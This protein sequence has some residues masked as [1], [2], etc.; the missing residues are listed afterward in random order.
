M[1]IIYNNSRTLV[2]VVCNPSVDFGCTLMRYKDKCDIIELLDN[3]KYALCRLLAR[4]ACRVDKFNIGKVALLGL[5]AVQPLNLVYAWSTLTERYGLRL[6][7]CHCKQTDN[8][9]HYIYDKS[10]HIS[11]TIIINYKDIIFWVKVQKKNI[12]MEDVLF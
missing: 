1:R 4:D 12:S 5:I 3:I 7:T 10:S 2:Y 6:G 8:R 11:A 9:H